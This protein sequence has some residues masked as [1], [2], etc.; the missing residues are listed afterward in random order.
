[1]ITYLYPSLI[2]RKKWI[3]FDKP[4]DDSRSDIINV[5]SYDNVDAPGF[6]KKRGLTTVIDLTESLDTLWQNMRQSFIRK[7]IDKG[8][9]NGIVIKQDENF[10][11]FKTIYQK[12]RRQKRL[13]K[14][15]FEVFKTGILFNAYYNDE[16]IAGGV[17]IAD[18]DNMRAWVLASKRFN[19]KDGKMREIVGQANRMLLWEALQ[20]AKG[21]GRKVFDL[22]GINPDSENLGEKSLAEFKEAF[23]GKRTDSYYYTKINSKILRYIR[24]IKIRK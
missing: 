4:S 16:L 18:R 13:P 2:F 22:G 5:F 23:G 1:M 20:Y 15:K 6:K 9:A 7:Q 14:D 3:W 8:K 19:D 12:F 11:G 24:K 10:R 21:S 17:F